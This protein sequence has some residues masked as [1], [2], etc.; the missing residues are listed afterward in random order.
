M[1]E[2]RLFNKGMN[3]DLA[4]EFIP[5]GQYR[6]A[7]NVRAGYSD[8]DS[9]GTI[10]S[11]LGN[12]EITNIDIP[13][14]AGEVY[15]CVGQVQDKTANKIYY[16]LFNSATNHRIM[17]YDV[18]NASLVTVMIDLNLNFNPDFLV[19]GINVIYLNPDTPLLYWTDGGAPNSIAD[20]IAGSTVKENPPRM[21]NINKAKQYMLGNTNPTEAYVVVDVQTLDAI[22][23]QPQAAPVVTMVNDVN[24]DKNNISG[25]IFQFKSAFGFDNNEQSA[26]SSISEL[27]VPIGDEVLTNAVTVPTYLNNTIDITVETGPEIATKI[28]L[29]VR[30]SNLSELAYGD[31]VLIT[32]LDK[33]D[34]AGNVLIASNSTYTYRFLNNKVL[35]PVDLKYSILPYDFLPK[36]AKAQEYIDS[37]VLVYGNTKEQFDLVVP[38]VTFINQR[39]D[40]PEIPDPVE[41]FGF[42]YNNAIGPAPLFNYVGSIFTVPTL[43]PLSVYVRFIFTTA[44]GEYQYVY[45][46]IV[47]DDFTSQSTFASN[48]VLFLNGIGV[49]GASNTGAYDWGSGTQLI[50]SNMVFSAEIDNVTSNIIYPNIVQAYPTYADMG[51]VSVVTKYPSFKSGAQHTFGIVYYDR[52]GRATSVITDNTFDVYVP[53]ATETL[54]T[55]PYLKRNQIISAIRHRPPIEATYYRILYGGRPIE[56]FL[57]FSIKSAALN[58]NGTQ[59]DFNLT[60]IIDYSNSYSNSIL[61][62]TYTSGDRMRLITNVSDTVFNSYVDVVITGF[63]VGTNVLT[64]NFIGEPNID[65][66]PGDLIELYTPRP[67]LDPEEQFFYE[68][69]YG[70]EIGD[71]GLNT[72]YHKGAEQDQDPNNPSIPAVTTLTKGDIWVKPREMSGTNATTLHKYWVEAPN[73]SDFYISN[74]WNK[75][76]PNIFDPNYSEVH[77]IAKI[78]FSDV[79]I[80]NTQVNGLNRFYP[81]NFREYEQKYRSIQLLKNKNRRLVCFQELKVGIIPILA[82]LSY[83]QQNNSILA[84]TDQV[85]NPIEYHTRENGIGLNPESYAEKGDVYYF[86]DTIH[87]DILRSAQNGLTAIS[88]YG[89]HN[90]ITDLFGRI[91]KSGVKVNIF[92]VYNERFDQVEFCVEQT[93]LKGSEVLSAE[94]FAFFEPDNY[95]ASFYDYHPEMMSQTNSDIVTFKDGRVWLHNQG[96]TYANFYGVQYNSDIEAISNQGA[97]ENKAY[98]S[99][100]MDINQMP[101]VPTITTSLNQLSN[102]SNFTLKEGRYYKGFRRDLLTVGVTDPIVNGNRMRG[103]WMSALVRI[104]S[105]T[106]GRLFSVTFNYAQSP[107]NNR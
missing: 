88:D 102:L 28:F 53:F 79:L 57:Q 25:N 34:D 20:P 76:R 26:T 1:E 24:F 100:S 31:F 48:I 60:P 33:Y 68:F 21:I 43:T 80:P 104:G 66:Q 54:D 78:P 103:K 45:Y 75:G 5:D 90:Y 27:A 86:C 101:E 55:T 99:M 19:T 3:M 18:A 11:A 72:R 39:I 6:Y 38:D 51:V 4:V 83:D 106:Y 91:Q 98:H 94:T 96:S 89:L 56:R 85:L 105:A 95:W 52:A 64:V 97:K 12:I 73:F 93:R 35:K 81:D 50:P 65:L 42:T 10:E 67:T 71:A 16:L 49:T 36:T 61:S 14:N 87:G 47:P 92:A 23:W 32:A 82:R 69:G 70:F 62:Y 13:L 41:V 77:L 37:N 84:E 107:I 30:K 15:K 59:T 22:K 74:V 46:T 9:F 63:D 44:P 40:L 8:G 29:Y 2:S 7:N 17:E 58:A